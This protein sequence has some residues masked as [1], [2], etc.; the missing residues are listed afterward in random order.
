M[1]QQLRVERVYVQSEIIKNRKK[2]NRKRKIM[3]QP[4]KLNNNN[5]EK[6]KLFSISI[7]YHNII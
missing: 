6:A 3:K 5:H 4:R 2:Q 1:L 7:T